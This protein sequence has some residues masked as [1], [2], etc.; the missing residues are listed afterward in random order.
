MD[1]TERTSDI[2]YTPQRQAKQKYNTIGV[3]HHYAQENTNNVNKLWA[4]NEDTIL[5]FFKEISFYS[6][7]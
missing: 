3:G 2:V 1:N 6:T 5:R 4:L 7:I